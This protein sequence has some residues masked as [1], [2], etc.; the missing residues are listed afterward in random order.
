[1]DFI[2]G[3]PVTKRKND[4]IW[5]VVD[6]LTKTAHFFAV[7]STITVD[8]LARLYVK[9][10]VRLHG[11]PVTIV[12]DRDPK[13]TSHF[14]ESF[15]DAMQTSLDMSTAYHPQTN[16]QTERVNQVLEDML[17]AC[18]LDLK[19]AWEEHL[20]LV[21]FAYNNSYH[22]SIGMTP[23]EALYGRPCRSPACWAEVGDG[24]LHGPEIVQETT[25]KIVRIRERL[26]AA[27]SRQKSYAD[28]KR[29]ELDFEVGDK[30]FIRVSPMRGV[31]RFGV[32]GKLAPR[33]IGPFE[34]LKKIGEVAYRLQ[35]PEKLSGVHNVFH[36][37][38]LKP[39]VHDPSH[40]L[41]FKE[42]EVRD[43]ETLVCKPL[44]IVDTLTKQT[45]R[46]TYNMVKVQWSENE[47]DV[48]WELEKKMRDE[49]PHLF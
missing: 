25:E 6:R 40:V 27:Q 48:T 5:V 26:K 33:F 13:F 44:K 30:V 14:W 31:M 4:S 29:R 10:V 41:N 7:K 23:Y 21:E 38:M 36:A 20:H 18:A 42:L 37:S 46:G 1:M 45:R 49:Q 19:S 16:E 32:K 39:Y 15:Q 22:S 9:E 11:A 17:R 43:D 35:L 12:S 34:V 3:L 28:A 8:E 2:G 47:K 24:P